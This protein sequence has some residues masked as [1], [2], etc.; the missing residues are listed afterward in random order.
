MIKFDYY[1]GIEAEQFSFYRIPKLL[2]KDSR[3][4]K[5]SSDA[6]L[7]YGLMLDRMSLSIKNRW[8]DEKNRA[9]IIYTVDSIMEDLGCAKP[10]CVK[11]MKELDSE[12]GIG[13]IEKKRRG[14]G[15]PDI[16]Y[17]KNFTTVLEEQEV[18]EE[19]K[20]LENKREF[21]EVQ[22][23]NFKGYNTDISR[24]SEIELQEV[25]SLNPQKFE[26]RTSRG[27][28][29]EP[30]KVQKLNPNNTNIN[31]TD[32][33][34]TN[35]SYQSNQEREKKDEMDDAASYIELIKKHINYNY[36]M[37]Y[38]DYDRKE[39]FDELF[40]IICEVVCVKKKNVRIA[41]DDY[42]YEIVK[43]RF[44]KLDDN[45]LEYVI[46]C[47][48]TVTAKIKNIK[49]YM[50]TALYNAPSTISHHYQND[51]QHNMLV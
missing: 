16:I 43:S 15:K 23:M 3:F 10:T 33:N 29:F 13:L 48:Q 28:S 14:L 37:S 31:N 36:H 49:S 8:L 32:M 17:V 25:Q 5:L 27:T 50:V 7:L 44:L 6:K 26:N 39:L 20:E 35:Q 2:M 41:G 4:K 24:S 34:N 30:T 9:Y 21:T 47:M 22:N 45:H 18:R 46:D 51:I 38:D 11:I 12:K 40:Q 42:P 19:K 1:Y